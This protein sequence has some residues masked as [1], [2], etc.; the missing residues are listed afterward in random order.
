MVRTLNFA[1]ER[2]AKRIRQ[3]IYYCLMRG[4]EVTRP[5][6]VVS[7]GCA[8]SAVALG[9]CFT[10][11]GGIVIELEHRLKGRE[12]VA[13]LAHELRHAEQFCQRKLKVRRGRFYWKG[14][15][16]PTNQEHCPAE[17]AAWRYSARIVKQLYSD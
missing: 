12:L 8:R 17:K 13:I 16:C 7:T 9:Q 6:C 15:A 2:K 1:S 3:I 10:L 5:L 11:N 4:L 14:I